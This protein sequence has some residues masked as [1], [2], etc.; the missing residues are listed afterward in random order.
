M[1][2][3]CHAHVIPDNYIASNRESASKVKV[4]LHRCTGRSGGIRSAFAGGPGRNAAMHLHTWH[5]GEQ[6]ID[7]G[8]HET[9]ACAA[10]HQA[11]SVTRVARAQRSGG[12][13]RCAVPVPVNRTRHNNI[14]LGVAAV[15]SSKRRRESDFVVRTCACTP[16]LRREL[17]LPC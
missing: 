12:R 8:C 17:L 10:R 16:A 14:N 13:C 9:C 15:R 5:G 7:G 11:R 3:C 2:N 6:G 4:N 1:D